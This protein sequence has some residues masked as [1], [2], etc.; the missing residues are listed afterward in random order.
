MAGRN[1]AAM[2]LGGWVGGGLSAAAICCHNCFVLHVL[3][4]VVETSGEIQGVQFHISGL[5]CNQSLMQHCV[6]F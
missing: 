6:F 4:S 3:F 1:T 5:H 2:A